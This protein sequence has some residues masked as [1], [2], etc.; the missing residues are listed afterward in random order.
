MIT[1]VNLI[2]LMNRVSTEI[3]RINLGAKRISM[4]K[5]HVVGVSYTLLLAKFS[6]DPTLPDTTELCLHIH[7]NHLL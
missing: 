4:L 6:A 7:L 5:G 1:N 3:S 2:G